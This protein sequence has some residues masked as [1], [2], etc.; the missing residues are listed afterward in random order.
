MQGIMQATSTLLNQQRV[1]RVSH[2]LLKAPGCKVSTCCLH[3]AACPHYT[4][5]KTVRS[6]TLT[7]TLHVGDIDVLL[8]K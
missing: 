5:M 3:T 8:L 1:N 6:S 4:Y 2:G 7:Y